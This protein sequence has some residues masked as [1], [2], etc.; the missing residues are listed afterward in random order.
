LEDLAD[1]WQTIF[2]GGAMARR[3]GYGSYE[4]RN[5]EQSKEVQYNRLLGAVN[6]HAK[7]VLEDLNGE[8]F[9]LYLEARLGFN[10][11][12]RLLMRKQEN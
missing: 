2:H 7:H 6:K 4:R 8:P 1:L 5:R 12:A 10:I 9:R 3:V 11:N